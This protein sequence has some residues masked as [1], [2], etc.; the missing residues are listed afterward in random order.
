MDFF[1]GETAGDTVVAED[2]EASVFADAFYGAVKVPAGGVG[3]CMAFAEAVEFGRVALPEGFLG[4][5]DEENP[6]AIEEVLE[7]VVEVVGLTGE[8]AHGGGV[9]KGRVPLR[10]VDVEADAE[11]GAGDPS[12]CEA[13]FDEH[14]ADLAVV[15]VDVV[16]PFDDGGD[17]VI[18]AEAVAEGDG[19]E[20]GQP[21]LL[22]G[23]QPSFRELQQDGEGEVLA[24]LG[25]PVIAPLAAAVGLTAGGDD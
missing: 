24:G 25:E 7:D 21:H 17:A 16:G 19:R 18:V 13:V 9:D 4:E 23:L 12:A 20:G 11:D 6:E 3:P 2:F 8:P 14:A 15:D 22:A 10:L 1:E 5:V